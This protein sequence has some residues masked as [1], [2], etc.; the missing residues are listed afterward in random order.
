MSKQLTK[1]NCYKQN[2]TLFME[3][4]IIIVLTKRREKLQPKSLGVVLIP[5]RLFPQYLKPL[6]MNCRHILT[7]YRCFLGPPSTMKV[8]LYL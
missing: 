4:N 7:S 5:I 6:P 8:R 3:K 2:H 1:E